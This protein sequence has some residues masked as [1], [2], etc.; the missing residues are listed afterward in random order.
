MPQITER[1][2]SSPR[3]STPSQKRAL[4]DTHTSHDAVSVHRLSTP[5]DPADWYC[6]ARHKPTYRGAIHEFMFFTS[7]VWSLAMCH[8]CRTREELAAA[9]LSCF[10][11]AFLFL[12]SSR[13]HRGKWTL[14][15][16]SLAAQVDFIAISGMIT[17]SLSPIYALRLGNG[18]LLLGGLT[19]LGLLGAGL[20][21]AGASRSLRTVVCL[22]QG[23]FSSIPIAQVDLTHFELACL[24]V[25]GFC[26]VGGSAVYALKTPTLFHDH[27]GF[28][29][30]WH[31]MI[32][33]AAAGTYTANLSVLSRT[34]IASEGAWA[35]R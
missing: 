7:P 21:I 27:F 34:Q 32:V 24:A 29:E 31:L 14:Q 17:Y 10:A 23:I 15:Q 16:E 19:A 28:H 6:Y 12:A 26:Y 35:P 25:A 30:L 5:F 20:T 33:V 13:Y 4:G 3:S 8:R 22:T 9:V 2:R 18:W 1:S 11:A